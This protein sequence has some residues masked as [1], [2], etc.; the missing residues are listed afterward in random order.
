MAITIALVQTASTITAEQTTKVEFLVA[1]ADVVVVVVVFVVFVVVVVVTVVV[2][3]VVV[4][5]I[6]VDFI[7]TASALQFVGSRV[8][9][10]VKVSCA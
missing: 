5:F 3:V 8:N 10:D 2:V 7:V 6:Y 4:A 1:V 9:F